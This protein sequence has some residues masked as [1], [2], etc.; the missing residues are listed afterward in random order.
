M[1]LHPDDLNWCKEKELLEKLSLIGLGDWEEK[2]NQQA[3]FENKMQIGDIVAVKRGETLIALVEVVGE[4]QYT[5]EVGELDWFERRRKIKLLDWYKPEYNYY[6]SP[7]GT[8]TRCDISSDAESNVSIL[9]WYNNA[10]NKQRMEDYINLL[11]YK[12][13]IILQGPPGTGKTRMAKLMAEEMTLP[14]I[15]GSPKEKID[16]FFKTFDASRP[17]VIQ[18]RTELN[19]LLNEFQ[20]NFSK[21]CLRELTLEEYA[22]GTGSNDSFCWWIERG[23]KPLGYYFPGTARSYLLYWS[24]ELGDYSKHTKL[25]K[26]IDDNSEA[27]T[28][29]A[30]IIH[31][32]IESQ[33]YN[34]FK[35]VL[36]NSFVL[37]LFHSYYPEKY[38]PINSV[39]C[40]NNALK[41]FGIEY[42]RM[43]PIE[44]NLKVQ[45]TYL[46]KKKQFN[47]DVTNLEF[48]RFLF[49]NFDLKGDIF[50]QSREVVSEGEY[51]IIQFHPAYSYEDFVRGITAEINEEGQVEYKVENRILAEFAEKALNNSSGNFVLIIDEINRANLPA[52][53]GELIYTMEYRYDKNNPKGTTVESMYTLKSEIEGTENSKELRLPPNLYIIGTMNTADRSVGHIDYAMRRRFAFVDLLPKAIPELT[54]KGKALFEDVTRLFCKEFR[55]NDFKLENSEFL[56]GDF[57]PTDVILGH[58]YFLIKEEERTILNIPDEEILKLKLKYE[59]KPILREYL[60]DGILLEGAKEIIE[61][62]NA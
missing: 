43:N 30:S 60:K 50:V 11:K 7:R 36:G 1:Q 17:E 37:K 25:L 48:M 9:T 28:K 31:E 41:L 4:Y 58:S 6:I 61:D 38:F 20:H 21:D 26:E 33:D 16:D 34:K 56:A 57:K 19:N 3:D 22:I 51:K 15:L 46:E 23:L 13:Q 18:K 42:S 62:L 27:M 49:D 59:I 55:E 35:Q 24:K 54:E 39:P 32:L 14:K 5:E 10:I 47:A 45:E 52:V 2:I 53:L 29:L 44:K 12:H 8:L 40:L